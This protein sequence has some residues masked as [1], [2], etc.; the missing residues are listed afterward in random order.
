MNFFKSVSLF[1]KDVFTK[2]GLNKKFF[3]IVAAFLLFADFLNYPE[4]IL[5]SGFVGDNA[6]VITVLK[7]PLYILIVL[8][9][10]VK[11]CL[12]SMY[13]YRKD[14]SISHFRAYFK[15]V[16]NFRMYAIYIICIIGIL[17][18]FSL[19]LK[20]L[21]E[22]TDVFTEYLKIMMDNNLTSAAKEAML[23]DV[24]NIYEAY[25]KTSIFEL[26]MSVVT[27]LVLISLTGS[28]LI[29]SIPLVVKSNKYGLFYS[30]KTSFKAV[31][32]NF[33]TFLFT[34][35]LVYFAWAFVPALLS[36]ILPQEF[37]DLLIGFKFNY[38]I[39]PLDA[40]YEAVV[41]FYVII[42]LEKFILTNAKNDV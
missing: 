20:F 12:Y 22:I 4:P 3:L 19:S 26:I 33:G 1:H 24:G 36:T 2:I 21:K 10:L 34:I 18:S 17:V 29:F 7:W 38:L 23:K 41:F 15:P 35:G 37:L 11:P 42:G 28:I 13:F 31:F 30:I 16:Y 9:Y 8:A 5:A 32:N 6:G 25:Q 40:L 27:F 39:R 14:N